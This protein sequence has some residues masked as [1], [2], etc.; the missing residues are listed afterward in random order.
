MRLPIGYCGYSFQ[1]CRLLTTATPRVHILRR[2]YPFFPQ[3][4]PLQSSLASHHCR[5][6]GLL[7]YNTAGT[8]IAHHQRGA[9][10]AYIVRK[11]HR[12]PSGWPLPRGRHRPQGLYSHPQ[13]ATIRQW[14]RKIG[15]YGSQRA[16]APGPLRLF[17][18]KGG[19]L[20]SRSSW[21]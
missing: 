13:R 19:S 20:L 1:R 21:L 15:C 17:F 16:S 14:F 5:T 12:S 9:Q 10:D 2:A 4:R 18:K 11:G 7:F 6:I 3:K 8:E